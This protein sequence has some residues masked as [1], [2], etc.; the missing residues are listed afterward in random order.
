[1]N[2]CCV[3]SF[4]WL[5]NKASIWIFIIYSS[6]LSQCTLYNVYISVELDSMDWRITVKEMLY[7]SCTVHVNISSSIMRFEYKSQIEMMHKIFLTLLSIQSMYSNSITWIVPSK[8]KISCQ[9]SIIFQQDFNDLND[10]QLPLNWWPKI[11]IPCTRS[12]NVFPRHHKIT[13]QSAELVFRKIVAAESIVGLNGC[14][15]ANTSTC[16]TAKLGSSLTAL[17]L[18]RVQ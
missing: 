7:A 15:I 2:T 16:T 3:D 12:W 9:K 6:Q 5:S 4:R 17:R 10:R 1:M 14:T 8:L 18:I 11:H 13:L